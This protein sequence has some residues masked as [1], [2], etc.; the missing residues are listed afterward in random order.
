MKK[1][2]QI[3]VLVLL[4]FTISAHPANASPQT[5]QFIDDPGNGTPAS[6]SP[7][8][9]LSNTGNSSVFD[10]W[11]PTTLRTFT[12]S[13]GQNFNVAV[14]DFSNLT[15]G[16][17]PKIL[18]TQEILNN[19][20][21][22]SPDIDSSKLQSL[23]GTMVPMAD[24]VPLG[25]DFAFG[26]K[27]M[28]MTTVAQ[29]AGIT[30]PL[31]LNDIGGFKD[32]PIQ[33]F[34]DGIQGLG[35]LPLSQVPAIDGLAQMA[36]GSGFPG[37]ALGTGQLSDLPVNNALATIPG[38][39]DMKLNK[40]GTNVLSQMP[41]DKAIPGLDAT[42]FDVIPGASQVSLSSLPGATSIPMSKLPNGLA[43]AQTA[44][45][46]KM[47][48]A[49]QEKEQ[50]RLRAISGTT[51]DSTFQLKPIPCTDK[52]SHVEILDLMSPK[53]TGGYDGYSWMTAP[54]KG[55]DCF[56][57]LCALFGSEGPVGTHP[58]GLL[59]VKLSNPSEKAGTV[60]MSLASRYCQTIPFEG[61]TCSSHNA[62]EIPLGKAHEGSTFVIGKPGESVGQ[63]EPP[64]GADQ[65]VDPSNTDD[66]C[67][68]NPSNIDTDN[69]SKAIISTFPPAQQRNAA[70]C[71][72]L[73]IS[74]CKK[75]GVT[76]PA[77]IAY[78]MSTVYHESAG[79]STMKEFDQRPYDPC[80]AGEG[81]IQVTH[82]GEKTRM[83][84]GLGLS[85]YQGINDK[86]LQDPKIAAGAACL[87][88]GKGGFGGN[89]KNLK[90]CGIVT[91]G[92]RDYSCAR[93]S[94]NGDADYFYKG[95]NVKM[96]EQLKRY[97]LKFEEA[98]KKA[99]P[100]NTAPSA[101]PTPPP[102]CGG[103]PGAPPKPTGGYIDPTKGKSCVSSEQGPRYCPNHGPENHAA[104]DLAWD[105]GTPIVASKEGRV[106]SV[107]YSSCGGNSI[108][109][110]HPDGGETR[111]LHL[112]WMGVKK[113][114]TVQQGQLIG[115][116]G[117]TGTCAT[118]THLHFEMY[119][120]ASSPPMNPRERISNLSRTKC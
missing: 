105:P 104:I 7:R 42:K 1:I 15:L 67:S 26:L 119:K 63:A 113:G 87:W 28:D 9:D 5:K 107:G 60:E 16:D 54:M 51:P 45:P 19:F 100:G 61:L 65:V 22:M 101:T 106:L 35:D 78:V 112:S 14:P 47:D 37:G 44:I 99:P 20:M 96:G 57:S 79:C 109:I 31:S 108:S 43:L 12:N 52:C 93:A 98:L 30:S 66:P 2:L 75:Y 91:G 24:I 103:T 64:P 92:R 3:I 13:I 111:Y 85:P 94:I 4:I 97:S 71:V 120:S 10:S 115:K 77:S 25:S 34:A 36:M 102:G 49:F 118:G 116:M 32:L 40:L 81:Y 69:A 59:R 8:L 48:I 38:L 90:D 50:Q 33:N 84:K 23:I 110:G 82:C 39:A 80:G 58:F 76:D 46:V 88:M 56:G 72:P 11:I 86:R 114:Q 29:L 62:I 83:I 74:E 55:P 117:A 18:V 68:P 95:T 6:S 70:K 73:I 53:A 89:G 41:L 21:K 27:D 17:F